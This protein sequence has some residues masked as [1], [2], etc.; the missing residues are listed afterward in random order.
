MDDATRPATTTRTWRR[1]HRST[2]LLLV[3]FVIPHV[4]AQF[5]AV[6]GADAYGDAQDA[7]RAVYRQPWIEAAL[8]AVIVLHLTSGTAVLLRRTSASVTARLSGAALLAFL[9][10]HVAGVLACRHL[11]G[12]DSGFEFAAVGLHHVT[13][14]WFF[15]PYYL[16][17][18]TALAA[19]L[20][21]ALAY[22]R[23]D[24]GRI[25]RLA[26]AAGL[27]GGVLIVAALAGLLGPVS[28]AP[29]YY[30]L[31]GGMVGLP[32]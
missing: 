31:F 7:L 30:R 9:P 32:P 10:V 11:F 12:L 23:P 20:G 3:G 16:L 6:G 18:T 2:G 26:V 28:V 5:A 27:A 15:V 22:G 24:R 13:T 21:S 8:L 29:A 14:A 4:I 17:A 1:G 19:H 25:V